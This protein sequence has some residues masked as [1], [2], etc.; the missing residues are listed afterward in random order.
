MCEDRDNYC[1]ENIEKMLDRSQT[2]VIFPLITLG[3]LTKYMQTNQSEFTDSQV[4]M[5]YEE[6][7][8]RMK[9]YL[10]HDLHIGGKYYDAYPSRNLPKYGVLTVKGNGLYEIQQPY[11]LTAQYLSQWIPIRVQE[12]IQAKL[13]LIPSLGKYL[14]RAQIAQDKAEFISLVRNQIDVNPANFEVVSFAVIKVHLEKFAC[15][16]YRDTRT[17][18]HDSGVD[19]STN[20]GVVYQIKKLNVKNIQAADKIYSELKANF[21]VERLS[22]GNVVLIIDDIAKDVKQYLINMKIQS[23]SKSELLG[24]AESLADPE[25]REKVLR[26]IYDEFRREYSSNI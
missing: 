6:C 11:K 3:L 9:E 2:K 5:A 17:S 25:D 13:G 19:L 24:L 18:A 21:D 14:I 12:Y 16:V 7:V 10:G 26:I 15:R 20:F 1:K 8:I 4:R 23:I 22:D